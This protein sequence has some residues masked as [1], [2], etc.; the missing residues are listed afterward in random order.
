MHFGHISLVVIYKMVLR[1]YC[2][3]KS[4]TATPTK[5]QKNVKNDVLLAAIVLG[6]RNL[7]SYETQDSYKPI[8][9]FWIRFGS[10]LY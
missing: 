3:F 6:Y 5:K 4:I 8:M 10:S 2:S 1:L 9:S 7:D